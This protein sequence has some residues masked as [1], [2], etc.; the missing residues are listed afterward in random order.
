MPGR[1]AVETD[2]D[3]SEREGRLNAYASR[4][5]QLRTA[6]G[7]S[8]PDGS[9]GSSDE[10]T[11]GLDSSTATNEPS[12]SV[13]DESFDVELSGLTPT[14]ARPPLSPLSPRDHHATT[15]SPASDGYSDDEAM[16]GGRAVTPPTPIPTPSPSRDARAAEA[17]W[18]GRQLLM[19][20]EVESPQSQQP[21]PQKLQP[22]GPTV[23]SSA[24]TDGAPRG[25]ITPPPLTEGD[26]L[27]PDA[28]FDHSPSNERR[29]HEE[30]DTVSGQNMQSPPPQPPSPQPMLLQP[31]TGGGGG[32]HSTAVAR[33]RMYVLMCVCIWA[34]K[35]T[36]NALPS[37]VPIIVAAR[38]FSETQRVSVMTLPP[39][40]SR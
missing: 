12:T 30:K 17:F 1:P 26:R 22:H 34:L 31:R 7:P 25:E 15:M 10:S 24:T 39:L 4:L 19:D 29:R 21:P 37:V 18:A 9:G 36:R 11:A 35:I 38:G 20:E 40:P 16:S 27:S 6:A 33:A 14:V 3:Q 28:I 23:S 5:E 2:R 32:K 8:T 13:F